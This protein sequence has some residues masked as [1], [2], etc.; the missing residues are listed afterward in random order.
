MLDQPSW[1]LLHAH[2]GGNAIPRLSIPVVTE[3]GTDYI[4]ETNLR[5]F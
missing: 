2:F 1:E 5:R 3:Q 4:V